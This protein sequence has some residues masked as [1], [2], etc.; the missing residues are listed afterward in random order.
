MMVW[1]LS[2]ET[3]QAGRSWLNMRCEKAAG[4]HQTFLW[5][6]LLR[7]GAAGGWLTNQRWLVRRC[8]RVDGLD[9]AA[10]CATILQAVVKV[11]GFAWAG[12]YFWV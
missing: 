6:L 8:N 3:L 9:H 12:V 4:L 7:F 11:H 1:R 2:L 5:L 10:L